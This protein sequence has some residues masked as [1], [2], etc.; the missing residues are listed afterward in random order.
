MRVQLYIGPW[1]NF[2]FGSGI[3]ATSAF[4]VDDWEVA[5]GG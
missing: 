3:S 5:L 2:T 1:W 4:P